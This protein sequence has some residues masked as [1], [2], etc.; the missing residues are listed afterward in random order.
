MGSHR[1]PLR[2][3]SSLV[4][5][6]PEQAPQRGT[7]TRPGAASRMLGASPEKC[8]RG[9]DEENREDVVPDSEEDRIRWKY[10]PIWTPIR[11]ALK[12]AIAGS[13]GL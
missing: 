1:H 8:R 7:P 10:V 12:T 6:A 4:F 11:A 9:S 3:S 2:S 13:V 5:N